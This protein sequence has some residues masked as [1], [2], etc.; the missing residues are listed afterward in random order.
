MAKKN[1]GKSLEDTYDNIK[2]QFVSGKINEQELNRNVTELRRLSA[3]EGKDLVSKRRSEPHI[4][5][6]SVA[7]I[8]AKKDCEKE[9]KENPVLQE[10]CKCGTVTSKGILANMNDPDCEGKKWKRSK[11]KMLKERKVIK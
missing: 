11:N 8:M 10:S 4:K 1:L 9:F 3:W 7:V 2:E 5:D 6:E